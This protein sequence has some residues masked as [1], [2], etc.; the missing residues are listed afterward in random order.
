[1]GELGQPGFSGNPIKGCNKKDNGKVNERKNDKNSSQIN[2]KVKD[3]TDNK[4]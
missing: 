1:V 3:S 4:K 2:G